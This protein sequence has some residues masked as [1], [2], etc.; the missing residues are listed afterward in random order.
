MRA[1]HSSKTFQDFVRKSPLKIPFSP[2]FSL[3][4]THTLLT[5]NFAYYQLNKLKAGKSVVH[6]EPFFYPLDNIHDWNKMYGNKGF[7][8]YQF[9][10][11]R[12]VGFDA[13]T[14]VLSEISKAKQGSFLAVLKTF[15]KKEALGM[16]SFPQ[17][18]VTL[19]LDF[20]NSGTKTTQLFGRLDSIVNQA[21]GRIYMAKDAR[22]PREMFE[23]G[24]PNFNE[25]LKY[26]DSGISSALSRR[27]MGY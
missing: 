1:N 9:V 27:L 25:F 7:Y 17:E 8:Q 18:G 12:D 2:P 11:P 10:V 22:M 4:N 13:I 26:R 21:K 19:A 23:S 16:L 15:G 3:V 14:D 20:P 24:Y 6:Y 5:F